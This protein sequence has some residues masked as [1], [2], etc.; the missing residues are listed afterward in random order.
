MSITELDELLAQVEGGRE[1]LAQRAQ[2][3][4]Q[5]PPETEAARGI[6]EDARLMR[7]ERLGVIKRGSKKLPDNFWELPRPE[8]PEASVRQS[9][10][11]ERR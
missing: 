2:Q 8:D 6:A 10:K 9:I 4:G 1:V 5:R 7:L 11:K 3:E